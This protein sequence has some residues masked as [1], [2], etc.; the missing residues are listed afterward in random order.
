MIITDK[1]ELSKKCLVVNKCSGA[2]YSYIKSFDTE[3]KE[4]TIYVTTSETKHRL[5]KKIREKLK[6]SI[7]T[8]KIERTCICFYDKKKNKGNL[9][10]NES[11]IVLATVTLPLAIVL[12]SETLEEIN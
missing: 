2:V 10:D 8:E 1:D 4:A 7:L 5:S 9:T 3:T 12:N 6:E 11:E